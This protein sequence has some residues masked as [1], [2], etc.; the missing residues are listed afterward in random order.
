MKFEIK[1][2]PVPHVNASNAEIIEYALDFSGYKY[3]KYLI[4][5]NRLPKTIPQN[6]IDSNSVVLITSYIGEKEIERCIETNTIDCPYEYLRSYLYFLCRSARW[7][8]CFSETIPEMR[9]FINFFLR[10]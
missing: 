7:N 6:I 8:E 1:K 2:L 5:N 10:R 4:E 3:V 9:D